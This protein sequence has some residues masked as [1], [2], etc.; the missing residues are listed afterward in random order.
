M[1][2]YKFFKPCSSIEHGSISRYSSSVD[3]IES[4]IIKAEEKRHRSK[5]R[6]EYLSIS[7]EEKAKIARYASEN[8]VSKALKHFKDKKLKESTVRGWQSTYKRELKKKIKLAET[9]PC[10]SGC[11]VV[12]ALPVKR[13]GRP[14]C[15]MGPVIAANNCSQTRTI[16][17]HWDKYSY[18]NWTRY[19]IKTR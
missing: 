3:T 19:I 11:N 17:A 2:I 6:G 5:K 7:Q 10:K 16:S 1:A 13:R 4:E 12:D 15:K 8:G 18:R 9:V 14:R